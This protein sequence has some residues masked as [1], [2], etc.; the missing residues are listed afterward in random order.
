MRTL[1]SLVI[2]IVLGGCA[3]VGDGTSPGAVADGPRTGSGGVVG[4]SVGGSVGVRVGSGSGVG[5]G[6]SS[7][8]SAV[9]PNQMRV[10]WEPETKGD[11][12]RVAGY[13]YN[14]YVLPAR[15]IVLLVEGLDAGGQVT[16]RTRA[17]VGRIV[18]P[19]SRSYW[20]VSVP[21]P[22]AATYRVSV[23]SLHWV[24]GGR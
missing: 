11:R 22:A 3:A 2:A 24:S 15:N 20:E 12:T 21:R 18:T 16:D 17:Y 9:T 7:G 1:A 5:V 14:D 10:E 13:V 8:V 23:A 19:G 4:G 6:A